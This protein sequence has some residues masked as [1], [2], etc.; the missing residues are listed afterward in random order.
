MKLH[1]D[2]KSDAL[3]FRLDD[4]EIIE[5]QEVEP[6]VVIDYN[7]KNQVVGL[8]ILRL[9]SRVPNANL[10]QLQFEVA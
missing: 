3:Y 8:E 9:K 2:E 4:S 7:D 1:Y 6:G 10:K 5:S